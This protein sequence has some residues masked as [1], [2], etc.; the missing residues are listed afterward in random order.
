MTPGQWSGRPCFVLDQQLLQRDKDTQAALSKPFFPPHVVEIG[1]GDES[2]S[3]VWWKDNFRLSRNAE[4][5]E[6]CSSHLVQRVIHGWRSIINH[7]QAGMD[8]RTLMNCGFLPI[9]IFLLLCYQHHAR[10]EF[11]EQMLLWAFSSFFLIWDYSV[12]EIIRCLDYQKGIR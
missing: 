6:K 11:N 8:K 9:G 1:V 7:T 5:G 4:I 2:I 12:I 10:L 3:M